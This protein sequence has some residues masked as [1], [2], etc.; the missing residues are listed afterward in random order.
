MTN[1]L[2]ITLLETADPEDVKFVQ[3]RLREFNEQ[4]VGEGDHH[5]TLA[6]FIRDPEQHIL[7]GLLG[8]TYWGWLYVSILWIDERLRGQGYGER[9]LAAA[10]QEAIRRGCKHAHLD[11]MSFQALPFYEKHGYTV[12]GVLEDLPEGH[13]KIFVQKKLD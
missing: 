12:V 2:S 1:D 8:D 11:T 13:K 10:E 6:I 5:R 4:K 3:E 7:G 9:L